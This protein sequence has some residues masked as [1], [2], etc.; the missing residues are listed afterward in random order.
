MAILLDSIPDFRPVFDPLHAPKTPLG[1]PSRR[2]P[3][4]AALEKR[5]WGYERA[6]V[7]S[8]GPRERDDRPCRRSLVRQGSRFARWRRFRGGGRRS[9]GCWRFFG[10]VQPRPAKKVMIEERGQGSGTNGAAITGLYDVI[11]VREYQNVSMGMR[12]SHGG[13]D[14][15]PTTAPQPKQPSEEVRQLQVLSRIDPSVVAA[16]RSGQRGPA[17]QGPA[18]VEKRTMLGRSSK[19]A[20]PPRDQPRF[21]LEIGRTYAHSAIREKKIA[22]RA[23]QRV[24]AMERR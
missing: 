8:N 22:R 16:A 21:E 7:G 23:A 17:L 19:T 13:S 11:C 6:N 3:S 2:H 1:P 20:Y 10:G 18:S 15:Q 24:D 14:S 9:G 4:F 12:N 5:G